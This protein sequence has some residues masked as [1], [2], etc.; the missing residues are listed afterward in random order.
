MKHYCTYFDRNYLP[1]GLALYRSLVRHSMPFALWVL[2][3]DETTHRILSE[4]QLPMLNPLR[5]EDFERGDDAL[6]ASK[7]NRTR[8][9]YFWT[10]TPSLP[11]YLFRTQP[12]IET[13]TYLMPISC[14]SRILHLSMR[15]LLIAQSQLSSIAIRPS[16]SFKRRSAASI[17]SVCSCFAMIR[18]A[19]RA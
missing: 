14:S 16:S 1:Q 13:I 15:R 6:V 5:Q 10:C 2:C 19:W 11:L 17:T 3:F 7:R 9:E 12:Q 18:A 4:L 8:V